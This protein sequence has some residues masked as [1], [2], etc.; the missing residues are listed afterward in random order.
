MRTCSWMLLALMTVMLGLAGAGVAAGAEEPADEAAV[1]TDTTDETVPPPEKGVWE[2]LVEW[3]RAGQATMYVLAAA[4]IIGVAFLLERLFGLRRSKI[5]PA[6]LVDRFET[7]CREGALDQA[8]QL[9]ARSPSTLGNILQTLVRHRGESTAELYARA[10]DVGSR[11]IR[12][13]LGR[14]YPLAVVATVS[15]ILGLMGTIFGMMQAFRKVEE[16]GK[17]AGVD[18]LAG[19]INEA[20][21]TTATGLIIAAPTLAAYHFFRSRTN[22]IGIALEEDV[23]RAVDAVKEE[24]SR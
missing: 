21:V 3:F 16:A 10:E 13:Q 6:G 18:T 22:S 14:A 15:P 20:L 8:N 19:G 17:M 5:A 11:E 2:K 12:R 9:A 23:T 7:L 1:E 4:S 24:G